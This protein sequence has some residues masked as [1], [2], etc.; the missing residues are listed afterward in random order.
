MELWAAST[1]LHYYDNALGVVFHKY[2]HSSILLYVAALL[3]KT[4]PLNLIM[5]ISDLLTGRV[6]MDYGMDSGIKPL[7]RGFLHVHALGQ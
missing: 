7:Q 6:G 1:Q 4:V 2:C 3:E 5:G